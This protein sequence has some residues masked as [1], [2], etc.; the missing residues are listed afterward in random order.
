VTPCKSALS[1]TVK[2]TISISSRP[3]SRGPQ[4]QRSNLTQWRQAPEDRTTL[5]TEPK[6]WPGAYGVRKALPAAHVSRVMTTH[7][8]PF[9][10][11]SDKE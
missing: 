7:R 5:Q 6:P 4:P 2:A 1:S 10:G 11:A 8:L 3:A 9:R